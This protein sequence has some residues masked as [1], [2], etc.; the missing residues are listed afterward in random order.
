MVFILEQLLTVYGYIV[1]IRAIWSWFSPSYDNPIY[2]VLIAMTE[3][4]LSKIRDLLPN[5]GGIDLS[6]LFLLLLLGAIRVYVLRFLFTLPTEF[7]GG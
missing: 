3:P 2:K 1:I 7:Y 6:P 4:V 5:T